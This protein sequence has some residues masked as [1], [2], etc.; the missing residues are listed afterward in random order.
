MWRTR[1]IRRVAVLVLVTGLLIAP[2]AW[3]GQGQ[4]HDREVSQSF[5]VLVGQW[6]QSV[7]SDIAG[8]FG[9]SYGRTTTDPT[10]TDPGTIGPIDI[11]PVTLDGGGGSGTCTTDGGSPMDPNGGCA[12]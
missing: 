5:S 6:W 4:G 8:W 2:A 7:V 9:V 3:A 1:A 10:T 12:P 11:G